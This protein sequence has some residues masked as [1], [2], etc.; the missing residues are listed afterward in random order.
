MV[1]RVLFNLVL[2][3][4]LCA[5]QVT[6]QENQSGQ[7]FDLGEVV[8]TGQSE[9]KNQIATVNEISI[10]DIKMQGAQTVAQA[11]ELIPGVDIRIGNKGQA[12]IKLRG[13]DQ[14]CVKVLIDGVPSRSTF[15]SYLDLG[16]IP[17]DSVAKIKV[18]KGASSVLYGSNT[19]GGVIN[20][21]TKKGGKKPYTSLTTSFGQNDTQNYIINHGASAGKINYW[22][23]ASHRKSDGYELSNDFDPDNPRTGIG[24][25]YNED[26]GIRDL[27]YYT[28]NTL[29]AKLGYEY[30]NDSEIYLSIDYHD[31]EKGSPTE[32]NRYWAFNNWDQRHVNLAGTHDI[33]QMLSMKARLYYIKHDDTLEDVSWDADHTTRRKWFEQSTWDDYTMGGE[34][35]AFLDFGEL[36]FIKIGVSYVKDN[37]VKFDFYDADTFPVAMGWA[38]V[39]R[40]PDEEYEIDTYSYGIEDEILFLDGRLTVKAGA[41]YDVQDPRKSTENEDREKTSVLNPQAGVSFNITNDF[42]IY[43]S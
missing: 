18:I 26:G 25:D 42:D 21:I 1:K 41:S 16:Q 22:V 32:R 37:H 33:T 27:S 36:S 43:A 11:L 5:S 40:Q 9:K 20:I 15:Y 35:H 3:L 8:V 17:I 19:M 2:L 4:I 23:T 13:F 12:D 7:V 31:N 29:S 28:K 34:V 6:A 10:E 14:N 24:T 39:G 38:S 30:D